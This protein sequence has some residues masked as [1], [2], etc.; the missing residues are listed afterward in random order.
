MRCF[1]WASIMSPQLAHDAFDTDRLLYFAY[2]LE[3][4]YF[5]VMPIVVI[6]HSR[7]CKIDW[8]SEIPTSKRVLLIEAEKR[9]KK[10]VLR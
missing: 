10:I 8:S 2:N 1:D 6:S 5:F 4:S 9:P 3:K 7:L